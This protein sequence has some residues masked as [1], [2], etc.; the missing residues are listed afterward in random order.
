MD[1][2]TVCL[3]DALRF[4]HFE[5]ADRLR[6]IGVMGEPEAGRLHAV[7]EQDFELG[8][9]HVTLIG[10]LDATTA[11]A[12]RSG[13]LKCAADHPQAVIVDID[14]VT[15]DQPRFLIVLAATA[16][17]LSD[18][19]I[20]MFVVAHPAT[21]V[22]RSARREL[23]D[24]LPIFDNRAAARKAT[25]DVVPSP[26]RMHLHLPPLPTSPAVARSLVQYA[27]GSWRL[28]RV[29]DRARLIISE[30]VTNAVVHA[31]T[32]LDVTVVL[33]RGFLFLQVRDRSV[34]LP[35]TPGPEIVSPRAEHGRGL[36]LIDSLAT[37]WGSSAA[38]HGKTVWATVRVRPLA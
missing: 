19:H 5:R 8:L 34:D 12:V 13:I 2:G 38:P 20:A 32:E 23:R 16:R 6:S 22:G 27:C 21:D 31:G 28:D 29:A 26:T 25:I 36:R 37:S 9:G 24:T 4:D 1:C 10:E 11:P 3:A 33:R 35:R 17:G 15:V 7:I 18:D 14:R 30:L